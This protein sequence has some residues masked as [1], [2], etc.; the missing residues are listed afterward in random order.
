M[1]KLAIRLYLIIEIY[2]YGVGCK[3]KDLELKSIFL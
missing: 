1:E 3:Q 2:L